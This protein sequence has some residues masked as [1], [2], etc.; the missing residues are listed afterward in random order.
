MIIGIVGA[1]PRGLS[2]VERLIR[3]NRENQHIQICLF[4]PDGPGGRVWRLDQP[5]E[6]LMNSVSQQV[7]PFTDETL[8]S[9]GEISP[10]PNLYQWSQTEAKKYIEKQQFVNK[11]FF[12]AEAERLRANKPATRCFYGLYQQWFYEQLKKLAPH[13]FTIVRS[14]VKEIDK[15]KTGFYLKTNEQHLV[16]D[17]LVMTTG[18]WENKVSKDEKRFY[19]YA[20]KEQLFYQP[21]ANP[22]DVSVETIPPKTTVILRGL[23]LSFFDYV[24][25]LTE[26]RGGKFEK[27]GEKLVY[28]P[29]G[30]E[31]IVYCG[32]RKGLPYFPRGKN[33]KRGGAM[34]VPK[35][36]TKENL[37]KLYQNQQLTGKLFFDLLKKDVELFYY[38]KLIE[39]KH[40]AISPVL[41]EQIFLTRDQSDWQKQFPELQPYQ[42][43]WDFFETPI[44]HEKHDFQKESRRFID[45]QIN[46]SMKGNCTGAIAS[47]FDALKDWRDPVHLVIEWGIFT[48]KEYREVL[49]GWFT[50]LNAF[51]TIGPPVVRTR[52]LAALIDAGIFTIVSPPLEIKTEA[53][54]F[55]V[56]NEGQRI[57]SRYLIEARLPQ[58]DLTQT[59]NPALN[60]LKKHQLIRPFTYQDTTGVYETGAIDI[61]L[62]TNQVWNK[63]GELE[64]NLYCLGIPVE[65]VDWLTATVSRPYTDAWNLRQID[66]VAQ[67]ILGRTTN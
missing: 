19:D 2:M 24:G 55:I 38:K 16:V 4:D 46:E 14:L 57:E 58:T 10:G 1:G 12:L 54:F 60:S 7:T 53:G 43:E 66:K 67:L 25:L 36:I 23:G 30:R 41:F 39:E 17:Q 18:H 37:A 5:T 6:L 9:G 49:W 26:N 13:S 51:L 8:T 29:S 47:A 44:Y 45:Y 3:N 50:K 64:E 63:Q 34:A 33:E 28:L 21:P 35:L 27:Q 32:S 42:W 61:K 52:E 11:E 40:L 59:K 20:E 48:A 62:S 31:P 15:I 65:G 22:A 56:E